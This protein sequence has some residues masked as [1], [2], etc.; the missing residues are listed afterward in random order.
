MQRRGHHSRRRG[1]RYGRDGRRR[2]QNGR[3]VR[4]RRL[5]IP[6]D[7]GCRRVLDDRWTLDEWIGCGHWRHLGGVVPRWCSHRPGGFDRLVLDDRRLGLVLDGR[8]PVLDGRSLLID[9]RRTF[10]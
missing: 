2:D 1:Q 4:N 9:E 3:H 5:R 7:I 6:V 10:G 8:W